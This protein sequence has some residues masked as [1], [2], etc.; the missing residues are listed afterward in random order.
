MSG[1]MCAPPLPSILG[2]RGRQAFEAGFARRCSD[3]DLLER[4]G[5]T[6]DAPG[7]FTLCSVSLGVQAHRAE[8]GDAT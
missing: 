3:G 8:N 5:L 6:S 7:A 4:R 2:H 1:T